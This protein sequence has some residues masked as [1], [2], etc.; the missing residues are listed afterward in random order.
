MRGLRLHI[1][2]SPIAW[3]AYTPLHSRALSDRGTPTDAEDTM[4]YRYN[5]DE[6]GPSAPLLPVLV[7]DAAAS[8]PVKNGILLVEFEEECGNPREERSSQINCALKSGSI[9]FQSL[10]KHH[11]WGKKILVVPDRVPA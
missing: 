7:L 4:T 2:P 5:E 9:H 10:A 8:L 6:G 1:C 3:Q 11:I